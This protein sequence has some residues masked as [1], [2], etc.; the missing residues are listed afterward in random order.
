MHVTF[1]LCSLN[2]HYKC[3]CMPNPICHDKPLQTILPM[4]AKHNPTKVSH[5]NA[6]HI[7]ILSKHRS[8]KYGLAKARS[9][10][11]SL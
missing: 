9:V 10:G 2:L 5:D 1:I 11:L 4:Y 6:F 8:S 7:R 3:E